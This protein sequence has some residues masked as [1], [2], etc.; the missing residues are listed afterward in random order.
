V[1]TKGQQVWA[2]RLTDGKYYECDESLALKGL[3]INLIEQTLAQID[4]DNGNL[5][6]WFADRIKSL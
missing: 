1:S 2:F 3:P 5:A 4:D 6:L